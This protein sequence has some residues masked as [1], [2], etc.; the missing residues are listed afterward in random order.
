MEKIIT[1]LV[2]SKKGVLALLTEKLA[3]MD[4]NLRSV[5]VAETEGEPLAYMTLVAD[6]DA[7][8]IEEMNR[9]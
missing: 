4:I 3:E 5:A 6:I 8:E 1:G 7:D 9:E 2:K